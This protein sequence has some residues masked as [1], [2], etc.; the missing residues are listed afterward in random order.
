MVLVFLKDSSFHVSAKDG[1][2]LSMDGG[3]TFRSVGKETDLEGSGRSLF[4]SPVHRAESSRVEVPPLPI[5]K[6]SKEHGM[7]SKTSQ[8]DLVEPKDKDESPLTLSLI[9]I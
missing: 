4:S 9:H 6:P 8:G 1:S 7:E 5:A 3:R 2:V